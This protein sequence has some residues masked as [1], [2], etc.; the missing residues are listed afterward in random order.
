MAAFGAARR[1][2]V[3]ASLCEARGKTSQSATALILRRPE[4]GVYRF[5]Y[6]YEQEDIKICVQ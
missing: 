1:D 5:D 3:A 4:D 6:E 2:F